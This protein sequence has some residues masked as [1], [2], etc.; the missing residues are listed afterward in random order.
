MI[1]IDRFEG[2]IAVLETD[3][4]MVNTDRAALP[5]EA[6]EGDVLVME[7]GAYT[8]DKEATLARREAVKNKFRNLLRR[9]ND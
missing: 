4:G 5:K 3:M 8:V 2:D 7:N 6:C 9:N 1:I